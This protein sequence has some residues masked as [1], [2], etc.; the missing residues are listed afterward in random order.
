VGVLSS[1]PAIPPAEYQIPRMLLDN[2]NLNSAA[3]V[4]MPNPDLVTPY[5]QQWTL[6]LQHEIKNTIFEVRYVG[7]HGT[8]LIRGFDYNQVLYNQNGFLADFRRAQGNAI[9]SKGKSGAYDPAIPGSQQLTVFPTLPLA[10]S[11]NNATILAELQQG[12]VGDLAALYQQFGYTAGPDLGGPFSFFTNPYVL[13]AN[14]VAN[15]GNSSYHALQAEIRRRTSAGLQYQFNYAFGKVLSNTT[16]DNQ[17]N[18]EPLLDNNSPSLEKARSPY[19]I[20]HS[21]KA[22]FYYELPYGPGKRWSGGKVMNRVLGGWAV[23]G[24]WSYISGEPFSVISGLG[25]LNRAAR[26]GTT[27]TASVNGTTLGALN[28]VTSGV[29]M[30]GNGPYFISPSVINQQDGRGA[31]FDR[32][33][34]G[35]VFFNP[36]AGTVG[37]LQRRLF[38]G[39]WQWS[40][41]MS[42]KKQFRLYERH[43]LD[44]HFDIFDFM[45]HPTF[46]IRP[47]TGGDYGS[48]TNFNINNTTFGRITSMN[49]NPRIIQIAAYYRF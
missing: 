31:E 20:T 41:D 48:V 33:F 19:D 11:L 18:F 32:T 45:N 15:G 23:A 43:T 34:D 8:K 39:P 7:N 29:Y 14:A 30:T 35:E 17:T 40:W 26:S 44:F 12:Q 21:F 25:T 46:Y 1:P 36:S 9:L 47:T 4:A 24:I 49:Y 2:Y 3:A 42:V 5:V 28:N 22:N 38:S 37:N 13:G 27:N 6:G 10:G 16:G